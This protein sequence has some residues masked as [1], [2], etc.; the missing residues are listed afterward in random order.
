MGSIIRINHVAIVIEDIENALGFW[1]DSLGLSLSHV[2][3]VPDQ[4]AL[5]AFLP[6]GEAEVELVKPTSEESGIARYLK[7]RGAGVHHI[8][9][10]VDDI[11]SCL[12]SLK[13]SDIR[14]I[15]E[16]AIIGTGG[17]RIAFIHPESTYGVLVE[18][19]E[20]SPDE[21]AIRL[22]RV[23]NL[24]DRVIDQGQVVAAGLVGFLRAFRENQ[25]K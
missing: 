24:A 11:D 20:L 19:Y 21:P 23:R 25:N 16:E 3:D 22:A 17:K 8:C 13:S 4:D 6:V 1:R 7:K 2:E 15:N 9:F 5:V 12:E 18:L 10:E 14:L